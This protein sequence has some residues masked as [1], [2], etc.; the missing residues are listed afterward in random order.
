VASDA[1]DARFGQEFFHFIFKF[2]ADKVVFQD[3]KD[4]DFFQPWDRLA[5]KNPVMNDFRLGGDGQGSQ[6]QKG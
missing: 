6:G 1:L 3:G 4:Q 2:L 5:G